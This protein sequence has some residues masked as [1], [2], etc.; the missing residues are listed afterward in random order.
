M[1]AGVREMQASELLNF[2]E[3][4]PFVKPEPRSSLPLAVCYHFDVAAK[5]FYRLEPACYS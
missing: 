2:F 1:D 3:D 5:S 4:S